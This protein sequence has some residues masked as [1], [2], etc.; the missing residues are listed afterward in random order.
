[1][2]LVDFTFSAPIVLAALTVAA[3]GA[4][5]IASCARRAFANAQEAN[6]VKTL[7]QRVISQRIDKFVRMIPYQPPSPDINNLLRIFADIYEWV[8]KE[9]F[10][11]IEALATIS[12]PS[13]RERFVKLLETQRLIHYPDKKWVLIIEAIAS[14]KNQGERE[15]VVKLAQRL[16]TEKMTCQERAKIIG[17][18]ASIQNQGEREHVVKLAQRLFTEKMNGEERAKIIK[19]LED[20]HDPAEREHVAELAQRF[21]TEDMNCRRRLFVIQSLKEIPN[22]AERDHILELAQRLFTE[23]MDVKERLLV[24]LAIGS[25]P[26]RSERDRML[27]MTPLWLTE[28]MNGEQRAAVIASLQNIDDL[29]EREHVARVA[30]NFIRPEMNANAIADL[31]D[32]IARRVDLRR[33][34]E[35]VNVHSGNRDERTKNALIELRKTQQGRVSKASET[36][37]REYMRSLEPI[38]G[39]FWQYVGTLSIEEQEKV[40]LVL[41]GSQRKPDFGPFF[42]QD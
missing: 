6:S 26:L 17:V 18:L 22:S 38:L 19:A 23:H 20:I 1:M 14:I 5:A 39:E 10:Y 4:L 3:G 12:N 34:I 29:A 11:I 35:A 9:H 32:D 41:Q 40:R 37:Y 8:G 31:F 15:H 30:R 21:F 13:E 28:N 33:P 7:A 16:F 36:N 25:I 24:I 2:N 27:E 42:T